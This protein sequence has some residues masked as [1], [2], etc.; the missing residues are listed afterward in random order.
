MKD[1]I[2]EEIE[3][4]A[5]TMG[6]CPIE[7]VMHRGIDTLEKELNPIELSR[8]IAELRR[9]KSGVLET[10]EKIINSET[11]TV[12]ELLTNRYTL[13]YYQR[14][15]NWQKGQ[16]EELLEDLTS[17]FLENYKEHHDYEAVDNY[18]HYFLG[19][20]VISKKE[21]ANKGYIVDG[22]QR[23]TTLTLLLIN[24]CRMFDNAEDKLDI[25]NLILS[26]ESGKVSFNLDVPERAQCMK[27]LYEGKGFDDSKGTQSIRNIVACSDYIKA[28]FPEELRG[29]VLPYFVDW[30]LDKVYLVE[31]MASADDDAYTIFETMNDRGLPLSPIDMLKGYLLTKITDVYR[32]SAN[33]AWRNRIQDLHNLGKDEAE[34]AIKAWLRSQHAK[35]QIDFDLIGNKFHRWVRNHASELGLISSNNFADFIERDFEFYSDWYCR[36]QEAAQSLTSGLECVYYNEQHNFTLQYPVLLA[37]LRIGEPEGESIR[38]IQIVARYLDILIHRYIWNFR[39]IKQRSMVKPMFSLIRDIRGK[40]TDELAELLYAKLAENNVTFAHNNQYRLQ[41]R[42]KKRIRLILARMTDYVET[43]SG[44]DSRYQDY[45][46][47]DIEHIWANHPE[48]YD[49][50]FEHEYDFQEYRDRIGGLLLLPPKRNK[51]LSDLSYEE[52][53]EHYIKEN[54]LAQSLHERTYERNTDFQNFIQRSRLEFRPC[55]NFK[56]EDLNDRQKLYQQLAKRI[57]NLERLRIPHGEEPEITADFDS[58]LQREEVKEKVWTINKVR[59]CVPPERRE[60]Y[61]TRHKNKVRDIYTQVAALLNL[62]EEKEWKLIPKFQKSYCALYVDRKT[63]FGVNFEGPSRF[64]VWIK[65]KEAEGLSNYCEFERYSDRHCR[66]DYPT[67]T[68]VDELLPI[69]ECVYGQW[70]KRAREYSMTTKGKAERINLSL[71]RALLDEGMTPKEIDAL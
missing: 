53:L 37:P 3:A 64:A 14:E 26:E 45:I 50:E 32:D 11:K 28:N 17:K 46:K 48:L 9:M 65:K 55:P 2:L 47:Y 52:K 68:S 43:Q 24:L 60:H 31:I 57:W 33:E 12:R 63:I 58:D 40:N 62:V 51:A 44:Q 35:R 20:I 10:S 21:E 23:L 56:K 4:I 18:S 16:V 27:A 49:E 25:T 5:K 1:K 8:F 42:D 36:L 41:N 70:D 59:A 61:E 30:L 22:Q 7:D 66:A 6:E 38:K 19:S 13:D 54:L 69:F 34:N 39:S 15:Y 67:S 29:Q 71:R